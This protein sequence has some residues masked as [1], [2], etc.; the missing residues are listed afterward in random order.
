M[1]TGR[2]GGGGERDRYRP[3]YEDKSRGGGGGGGGRANAPPSRHL[4][5]GNLSHSIEEADLTDQFMRFGELESVAFQPGRS[6]AFVNFHS[7]EDAIASMKALQGFPLAD[8]PLRIEFAKADKSSTPSHDGDHLLHRDEQRSALRGSPFS[9]RDSRARHASPTDSPYSDKSKMSDKSADPSEVLWIGFPALL[10]VDEVILR[11]AFAPFGEIEKITVFPGR[12]YAFVRF[13]NITSACRSKETLQGKLFGNPRVHICFARSDGG[14]SNN[15]RGSL[16]ASPSPHFKLNGRS[17]SSEHY[18]PDRNLESF[19]GDHSIRSSQFSH[20]LDSEDADA[21]NFNRKGSLL[22]GANSTYEPW[23]FGEMGSEPEPSQDMY[24][25]RRSPLGE[26]TVHFHDFPQKDPRYEDHWDSPDDDYYHP[27]AKKLKIGSFPPDKELPEYPFSDLEQEKRA[28]SRTFSD[29]PQPEAFNKNFDAGPLG[30]KQI[31]DHRMNQALPQREKNDH[32]KAPYDSFQAGSGSLPPHPV[33]RKRFTPDSD[34]RSLKDWKWEGTIAKGGTPVCRA[35]C[36]PVGKVMDMML[37]E[38]LDCTAR[39]SL[40]MLAKHYYQASGAWVVFFVPGSDAD[41]GS[42][43]EFMH[44]LEEKQRAAVAKL[45]DSN[46]LFLV[47]PS[48]FSEKVLKVPGKMSISGVVLRL[49]HPGS[50]QGSLHYP[51]EVKDTNLLSFN[52]DALY[53]NPSAPSGPFPSSFPDIGKSGIS[54]IS[55][56]GDVSMSAP[57][58]SYGGSFQA[59]GSVSDQYGENRHEY[60]IHQRNSIGPNRSPHHPQNNPVP[61]T[62]NIPP[63]ASNSS[64]DSVFQGYPSVAPP[65]VE[66]ETTSSHYTGGIPGIPLPENNKLSHQETKPSVSL[67]GSIASLQ[68]DQLAQLASTLLGQQRQTANSLNSSMGESHRQTSTGLQSD[69]QYRPSQN[70]AMQSSN[71]TTPEFSASQFGQVQQLQMQMQQQ[72][73]SIPTT[74]PPQVQPGIQGSQQ[75]QNT[76]NNQEADGDPQKRLQATLQLAAALLQ[77]IQRGKGT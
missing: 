37:P 57:P 30:Y 23:R 62:R 39:T 38:F 29:F 10:K 1:Q 51:N 4:W 33:E 18:R 75:P 34:Q 19:P 54:N 17:G 63:Y 58:G 24:E 47:P 8:N 48:D 56:T 60:P 25:H 55:F 44:Y 35:R 41:M 5:V 73:S 50:S 45:D 26:R 36:F 61:L 22:S 40:D 70:Y 52:A 7:E 6:Y 46:T 28:F 74:M 14:S 9:Q 42:Y 3:R 77:Q 13:R 12:S 67:P 69:N 20:N 43:N 16:N 2:G 21:Y 59:M 68:P 65:K 31:P 64:V 27:G 32:W 15:A 72:A 53:P 11:K 49:E 71:Q 76:S 66:Q